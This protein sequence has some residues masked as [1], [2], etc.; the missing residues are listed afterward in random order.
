[1]DLTM[2]E[3]ADDDLVDFDSTVVAEDAEIDEL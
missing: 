3:G 1:M 2:E